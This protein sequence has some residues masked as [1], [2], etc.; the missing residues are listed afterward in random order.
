MTELKLEVRSPE[1]QILY[2][3]NE[4]I[5]QVVK[6]HAFKQ[7]VKES[8]QRLLQEPLVTGQPFDSPSLDRVTCGFIADEMQRLGL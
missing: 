2:L 5:E 8:F 7:E 3:R 4:L 6:H 1:E